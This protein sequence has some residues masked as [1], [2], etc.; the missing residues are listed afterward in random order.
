M[1]LGAPFRPFLSPDSRS[2]R[3]AAAVVFGTAERRDIAI[4][5]LGA[6]GL[7]LDGT[8]T[9]A[10]LGSAVAPGGELDGD[11][12]GDVLLGEA[13]LDD[14]DNERGLAGRVLVAYGRREGG[15]PEVLELRGPAPIVR[16]A[17]SSVISS[18]CLTCSEPGMSSKTSPAFSLPRSTSS[19][20]RSRTDSGIALRNSRDGLRPCQVR[21]SLSARLS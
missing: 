10:A 3:G 19:P 13:G 11:G 7:R 5:G 12:L 8:R 14:E 18:A 20:A 16:V 17:P 21:M 2:A 15:T 4:K 9:G 6:G 1:I